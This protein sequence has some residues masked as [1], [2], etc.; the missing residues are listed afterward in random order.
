MIDFVEVG[1]V[2]IRSDHLVCYI[3]GLSVSLANSIL[4]ERELSLV[5]SLIFYCSSGRDWIGSRTLLS[6]AGARLVI[7]FSHQDGQFLL[8]HQG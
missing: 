2:T 6:L 5:R 8:F 1:L 3:P 4:S 7:P